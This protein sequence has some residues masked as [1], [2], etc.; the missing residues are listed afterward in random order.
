[1]ARL[2][3]QIKAGFYPAPKE[4]LAHILKALSFEG[5]CNV[6]DPCA[7]KG[8]ALRQIVDYINDKTD[9][10]A[11]P[12]AVELDEGRTQAVRQEFD[13]E[14]VLAP[15]DVFNC[16]ITAESIQLLYLNPP[17]DNE[18]GGGGTEIQ[19][20]NHCF[21]WLAIG[22]ILIYVVPEDKVGRYSPSLKFLQHNFDRL[23][24]TPFPDTVRKYREAFFICQKMKYGR[25]QTND[26]YNDPPTA[27]PMTKKDAGKYVVPKRRGGPRTFTKTAMTPN[28]MAIALES[29]PLQ[30]HLA[31]PE[32]VP[33][34]RPPLPLSKGH[35]AVL[36][37]AGHLNGIVRPPKEKPHVI[38][39]SCIKQT[40][41]K[42]QSEEE[43][44]DGTVVLKRVESERFILTIR[45][46]TQDGTFHDLKN[47]E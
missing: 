39:G 37:S 2:A 47:D 13:K 7:G 31:P 27:D 34:C 8:K 15:A 23:K 5:D 21:H 10:E 18:L 45:A 26:E 20:L 3:A 22:G 16:M 29:S 36:L 17:Y 46:A 40:Y 28:E 1:M 4:A 11:H 35:T 24:F 44:E 38:R 9:H 19:F 12:Y 43:R 42:E 33:L 25:N 32:P 14:H 6:L 30:R 41:I